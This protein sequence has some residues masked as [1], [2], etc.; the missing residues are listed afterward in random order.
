V[1]DELTAADIERYFRITAE[2]S[3]WEAFVKAPPV[4]GAGTPL[5]EDADAGF[6]EVVDVAWHGVITAVDHLLLIRDAGMEQVPARVLSVPTAARGALLAGCRTV[7]LLSSATTKERRER[8]AGTA[9]EDL[10]QEQ[11]AIKAMRPFF[12]DGDAD[13]EQKLRDTT[14]ARADLRNRCAE[15]GLTPRRA[16]DTQTIAAAARFLSR[17]VEEVRGA[18]V[19]SWKTLS[20]FAHGYRWTG[21]P[22]VAKPSVSDVVSAVAAGAIAANSA[23]RM[24]LAASQPAT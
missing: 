3:E 12:P 1:T 13:I 2:L 9:L 24:F 6:R 7:W 14:A 11:G 4:V 19:I 23:I 15:A 16:S 20:G 21:T 8:A 17:D 18:L 22:A 5:G 10:E